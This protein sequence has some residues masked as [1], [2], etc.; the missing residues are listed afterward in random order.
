VA[1]LSMTGFARKE[2]LFTVKSDTDSQ[3]ENA[4]GSVE[5]Q[6]SNFFLNVIP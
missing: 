1:I 6:A 3:Q 2:G 5:I 4:L